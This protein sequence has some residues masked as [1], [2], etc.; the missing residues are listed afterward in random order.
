METLVS[1]AGLGARGFPTVILM[2]YW[3]NR[4]K[5]HVYTANSQFPLCHV[6]QEIYGSRGGGEGKSDWPWHHI[7]FYSFSVAACQPLSLSLSLPIS[8]SISLTFP[9]HGEAARDCGVTSAQF[10]FCWLLALS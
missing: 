8:V 4:V 1:E 9:K 5:S 7:K 6:K 10:V 3:K 2:E